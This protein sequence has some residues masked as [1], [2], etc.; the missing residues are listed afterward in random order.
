MVCVDDCGREC[1]PARLAGGSGHRRL[2]RK[3]FLQ[4][5]RC[6]P[7]RHAMQRVGTS[8]PMRKHAARAGRRC[9]ARARH[10]AWALVQKCA[11]RRGVDA[12]RYSITRAVLCAL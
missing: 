3:H 9:D 10:G 11:T 6:M 7:T 1:L 2:L 4:A 12:H 8:L 5:A